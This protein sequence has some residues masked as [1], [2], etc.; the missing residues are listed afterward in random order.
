MVKM[1]LLLMIMFQVQLVLK[2]LQDQLV[3]KVFK[4]Q[5]VLKVILEKLVL[6]DQRVIQVLWVQL[7]LLVYL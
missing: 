1:S 7:E 4:D 5:L 6:Q 3:L 2:V